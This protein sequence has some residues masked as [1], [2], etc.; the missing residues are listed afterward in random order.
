MLTGNLVYT[1][2][3]VVVADMSDLI[4]TREEDEKSTGGSGW[5]ELAVKPKDH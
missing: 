2:A 5:D 3:E 4:F 1:T